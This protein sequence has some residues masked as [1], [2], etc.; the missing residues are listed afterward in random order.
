LSRFSKRCI[1]CRVNCELPASQL[2]MPD[3]IR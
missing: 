3:V 1:I 2:D